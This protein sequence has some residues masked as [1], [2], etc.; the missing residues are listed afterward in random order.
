M[1]KPK[2][3]RLT[4]EQQVAVTI[5]QSLAAKAEIGKLDASLTEQL[6]SLAKVTAKHILGS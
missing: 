4:P 1:E 5:F 2:T 6:A 3:E